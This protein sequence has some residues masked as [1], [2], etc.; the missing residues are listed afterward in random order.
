MSPKIDSEIARL[1]SDILTQQHLKSTKREQKA[2]DP[3][4]A[5]ARNNKL[6]AGVRRRKRASADAATADAVQLG[7]QLVLM[8][9]GTLG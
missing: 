5:A 6:V 3:H 9:C 1:K 4:A 8:S 7:K 2:D